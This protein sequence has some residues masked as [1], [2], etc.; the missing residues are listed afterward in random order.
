MFQCHCNACGRTTEHDE[1][2]I[3]SFTDEDAGGEE[4]HRIISAVLC[5]G[6]KSTAI[7]EK[8][9]DGVGNVVQYLYKPPRL[10]VQKPKWVDD[11]ETIDSNIY[12]LLVE[13]Y[14]AANDEQFRLL[15]MGVRA[16]LDQ[17][18]TQIV[19]DIGGFEQKLD[20]MV[21]KNHIAANHKEMLSIVI[22]AGSAA[23]HRGFK[24]PQPLLMQMISVMEVI[25]KQHY[26]TGPMLDTLKA[27]IPPRPPR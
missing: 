21:T 13:V 27:T 18:M 3:N 11:L 6:C 8:V 10:W 16:I 25:I 9:V 23:A 22:D 7:C 4:V 24:P 19:G 1:T 12:G 2:E 26:I 15:A 17:A 20:A 14:S 5:R